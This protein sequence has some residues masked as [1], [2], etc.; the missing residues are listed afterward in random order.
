MLCLSIK[1]CLD[2]LLI[3]ADVRAFVWHNLSAIFPF[4]DTHSEFQR[5]L[6]YSLVMMFIAKA[7]MVPLE[8]Y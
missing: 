8:A 2:C 5:A 3:M 7:F 6:G 1:T 4:L